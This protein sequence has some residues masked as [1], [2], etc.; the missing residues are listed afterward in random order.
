MALALAVA[1]C[2]AP[3]QTR[4]PVHR[5][6]APPPVTPTYSISGLEAVIGRTAKLLEA[7]LGKPDLDMQEGAA[8]KLQFAGPVCVLDAYL[9]PRAGGGEPVVT[10]VDARQI[11]GRDFDRASCVAAL[12]KREEAR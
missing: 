2:A 9:Y 3:E 12:V 1:A 4:P 10:Y 5:P 8:R 11:D 6:V 7:Q